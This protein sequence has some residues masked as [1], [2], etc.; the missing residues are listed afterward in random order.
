ME[1]ML[2]KMPE[3]REILEL[4]DTEGTYPAAQS[5]VCNAP[6]GHRCPYRR[7]ATSTRRT[8]HVEMQPTDVTR[9]GEGKE[10]ELVEM[11]DLE[12]M[13]PEAR[14]TECTAP[15]SYR[16]AYRQYNA[17]LPTAHNG[18]LSQSESGVSHSQPLRL[19]LNWNRPGPGK[20]TEDLCP[21]T[22]SRDF[23]PLLEI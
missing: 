18:M 19:T 23:P 2:V 20:R 12:C 21:P 10:E 5:T 22:Y 15:P 16:C 1:T 9:L 4:V 3:D 17:S 6:M 14:R 13:Y 11:V 8:S 7:Y